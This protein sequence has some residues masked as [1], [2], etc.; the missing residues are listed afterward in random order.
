[1]I[2]GEAGIG[3][4]S[5]LQAA[6]VEARAGG[7]LVLGGRG[8]EL[9][10]DFA[11][12]VVRQLFEPMLARAEPEDRKSLLEGP[13]QPAAQLVT[14]GPRSTD[15]LPSEALF[16]SLH[17]LYWLAVR[18]SERTPLLLAI[19]DAHWADRES[20]HFLGFVAGR[21]AELP[22][23]TVI[24]SRSAEPGTDLGLI[25]AI[26]REQTAEQLSPT[27]LSERATA[28]VVGRHLRSPSDA[29]FSAACQRATGG[30]PF[31]VSELAATLAASSI[32]PTAPNAVL[33]DELGPASVARAVLAR[34]AKLPARCTTLAQA[35]A[36]LGPG[37]SLADAA[38]LAGITTETD[39]LARAL[40]RGEILSPSRPVEFRHPMIGT[41]I[42]HDMGA[43]RR[44][45]GH[46]RAAEL[47]LSRG[48]SPERLAAH[49]LA[50]E[51]GHLPWA[52]AVLLQA[53]RGA[54]DRG[55]PVTAVKLLRRA[56]EED[57]VD[58][59]RRT[60]VLEQLGLAMT[61]AGDAE[62]ARYLEEAIE[63]MDDP[64]RRLGAYTAV[65][66]TY[67]TNGQHAEAARIA[68]KGRDE[69]LLPRYL[70]D[71]VVARARLVDVHT[72]REGR[73]VL[74]EM[75]PRSE[76]DATPIG[77]LVLAHGAS[78]EVWRL[79]PKSQVLAQLDRVLGCDPNEDPTD[80]FARVIAAWL[81]GALGEV[82]R[83]EKVL[84]EMLSRFHRLGHAVGASHVYLARAAVR[85]CGADVDGSLG[86]ARAAFD[87]L[88]YGWKDLVP[89]S[90]AY[91]AEA[92]IEKGDLEGAEAVLDPAA[93]PD[94]EAR[95]T[96]HTY[97][98]ALLQARGHHALATGDPSAARRWFTKAGEIL[99]LADMHT[100]NYEVTPW[101]SGFALACALRGDTDEARRAIA[102]ELEVVRSYG[103]PRAIGRALRV[104][105]AVEDGDCA[106]GLLR[107]AADVLADSEAGLEHAHALSDLGAALRRS[108]ARRDARDHL[109]RALALARRCGAT[110]L[111]Q[112]SYDELRAAG[113]RPS[114]MP[115]I[116]AGA[117]TPSE[118]RVCRLAVEGR[119]NKEIA[120]ALVV[121]LRTVET[122]LTRAYQ[123]LGI[124]SR[125][126]LAAA[127]ADG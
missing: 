83:A 56:L 87:G 62:G 5:L 121:S 23:L 103:V 125:D 29:V 52:P 122:H 32:A 89:A 25:D 79:V 37:C 98:P 11:F 4:S 16:S 58:E 99:M 119:T 14:D 42:E 75:Y 78:G 72:Q 110:A 12:G 35:V 21:M 51:P 1:M 118:L 114:T 107:E 123:K 97:Y 76:L 20:L 104:S 86:D 54:L 28:E 66:R 82:Q 22:V 81:A 95:W 43:E 126:A 106:I 47:L 84:E 94:G 57:P 19:D 117:L 13:A 65:Y 69:P 9:E 120:A 2:S 55:A 100:E 7:L 101:R 96:S 105:A 31:L 26:G 88:A 63:R 30:N 113:G 15:G 67:F 8:A 74:A 41:A 27:P 116:G 111:A 33:V 124:A 91:L 36:V 53:G 68:E 46:R 90:A 59:E 39:D 80:A 115:T 17:A 40:E 34:L 44:S 3:K 112:R 92:L 64:A 50:T 102:D 77:R 6:K 18:L 127:L 108:G 45:D 73:M 60:D 48:A 93:L 70:L 71:A 38:E 61:T 10:R 24:A 85:L 49:L 109:D